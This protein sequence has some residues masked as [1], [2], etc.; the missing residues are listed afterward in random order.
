MRKDITICLWEFQ[1]KVIV[2]L[3]IFIDLFRREDGLIKRRIGN[4]IMYLDPKDD[5]ISKTLRHMNPKGQEREPCFMHILRKETEK[6]MVALDLG[7]NI[8]YV[9]LLIA[10]I[11]GK[12]GKVYAL[13]PDPRTCNILRK[14][15]QA[16]GYNDFV[17]PYCLGGSNKTGN[18]DFYRSAHSNLGSMEETGHAK[19]VVEVPVSTMDDFFLDK[20]PP[21][22]IKM[23]IEGHEIEVLEGMFQTLKKTPP[24]VKILMEVHPKFYSE[25]HSL[26]VQLKRLLNI[27]FKT[28]YVVSA[29]IPNPD[30][31]VEKGYKPFKVYK[32]SNTKLERGIY[33]NISDEDMLA[34]VCGKH[35]QFNR[36]F[37]IYVN[38]IVRAIM[39]EK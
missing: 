21:H 37:N 31:F 9:T 29:G 11:V 6:G 28:K 26:E 20:K 27:G 22:F 36:N 35:R 3:G 17:Y 12:T 15:I 32:I 38:S 39:I 8:G 16:N 4:H 34:A 24:P 23:D 1:R 30:F 7:A 14:N 5:G 33:K 19:E 25:E 13:E 2:I 10:K 18:L